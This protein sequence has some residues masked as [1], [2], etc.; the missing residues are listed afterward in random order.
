MANVISEYACCFDMC[1]ARTHTQMSWHFKQQFDD[2]NRQKHCLM[3]TCI[4]QFVLNEGCL[5][6]T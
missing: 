5:C 6:T 2:L 1:T 3:Y 4:V